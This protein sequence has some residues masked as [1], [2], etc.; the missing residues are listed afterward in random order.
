MDWVSP[1]G[2]KELLEKSGNSAFYCELLYEL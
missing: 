2:R 1:V